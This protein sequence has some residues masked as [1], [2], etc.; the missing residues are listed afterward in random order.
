MITLIQTP[1]PELNDDRL[2]PP[3][4]LLS[5]ATVLKN[6]G[7][8]PQI[9]DL[10]GL[11]EDAWDFPESGFYGFST[12][13][14]SY[15]R[16]IKIKNLLRKKYPA[17]T[18][19]A[20][21]PHATALPDEVIK[22]FDYV[23]V[24]EGEIVVPRILEYPDLVKPGIIQGEPIADLNKLPFLDY[25]M[26]DIE[27]YNREFSD[28][29]AFQIFTSR[30]CPFKCAFCSVEAWEH[31]R[32][33]RFRTVKN[34]LAEMEAL[35]KKYGKISFRFKDDL[36][37]IRTG[38]LQEYAETTPG[39]PYSC[40]V[41]GNCPDSSIALLGNSGCEWI[42]IGAESGSDEILSRMQK[43]L[44]A[45]KTLE[46]VHRAHDAGLKVLGWFIVGFPGE[47]WETVYETVRL[48]EEAQFDKVVVYP[49]IPYPGTDVWKNADKYGIKIIDH[50]FSHYFYIHGNYESG[51]VYET[52]ELSVEL[53]K[54]MRDWVLSEIGDR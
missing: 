19:I 48:I 30:G 24:G 28:S 13:T 10:S 6:R 37:S 46:T 42:C 3:I 7:Y 21:G 53:I 22:E 4:G 25:D 20:G 18:M 2:D 31:G 34:V 16:T 49:L 29:L 33:V 32:N 23:V 50:D 26:V 17:A 27:S 5:I 39:Y 1:V 54:E 9:V 43:N 44:K 41:R 11:N 8:S 51:Y 38:W 40:N 45:S 12:Y 15:H 35:Y 47:R 36:F 52:K 14:A